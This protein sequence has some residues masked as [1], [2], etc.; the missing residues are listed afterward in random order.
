MGF[1]KVVGGVDELH[2]DFQ[3]ADDARCLEVSDGHVLAPRRRERNDQEHEA[4]GEIEVP[5]HDR[6]L[7][8]ERGEG[9]AEVAHGA[10]F[11]RC[12]SSG[13]RWRTHASQSD[14]VWYPP[15]KLTSIFVN[16]LAG[17]W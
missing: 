7:S 4:A 10:S 13:K 2:C 16:A 5:K 11:G 8:P 17:A 3:R 12:A 1:S 9:G 14:T 15:P 6:D